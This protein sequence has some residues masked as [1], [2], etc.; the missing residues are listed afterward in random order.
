MR[1]RSSQFVFLI[2]L[3]CTVQVH[4]DHA[5]RLMSSQT[6]AAV[7][8]RE[9][10]A[11]KSLSA[12]LPIDRPAV[13]SILGAHAVGVERTPWLMPHPASASAAVAV[14]TGLLRV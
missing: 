10:G 6:L 11:A 13:R 1:L 3:A 5:L 12:T 7:Q 2:L 9:A 4:Q 14:F 8:Q